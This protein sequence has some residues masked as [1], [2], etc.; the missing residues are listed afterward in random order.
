[1]ALSDVVTLISRLL[2]APAVPAFSVLQC[3]TPQNMA[4]KTTVCKKLIEQVVAGF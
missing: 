2:G 4:S 3:R 1:M